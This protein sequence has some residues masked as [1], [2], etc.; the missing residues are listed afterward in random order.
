MKKISY[1]LLIAGV[2]SATP[3][4]ADEAELRARIDKLSAE[5]EALKAEM[6]KLNTKTEAIATQQE[7][8]AQQPSARA[9]GSVVGGAPGVS[10]YIA[11][12][13]GTV[14]Q[15]TVF[16][17]GEIN[18]TR[19]RNDSSQTQADLR[20][21]VIGLGH[22]FSERTRFVSEFEFEHAITS[23]DDSGETEVEQFW[24]DHKLNDY[25]NLKAGLFLIPAGLLNESHEP[26]LYYGVERNFVE[27]AIIPSTWREGGVGLYGSA[28]GGLAWD[29]GVTTGFD[30][31]KW[32]ATSADGRESPLGSIHQELQLAKA[33]DLSVYGA[34]NYRGLPG[35][36]AGASIFTGK[37]GHG[38]ADFLAPNAR[39]TLWDT[40]VRW[41]PGK[42]DL[43]ALYAKGTIS[44]TEELNL[45]FIGQPTPVPKEFFGWYAQAAYKAW[46]S[47]DYALTPFL[48]YERYNTA[49]KYAAVPVDSGI[50]PSQTERV[51]TYGLHFNVTP[52]VVF[53]TDY[54]KF[55]VDSNRDRFDLGLGLLF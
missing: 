7:N 13:A 9:V 54:Q 18:Y 31:S 28:A 29:V 35:F 8:V 32:D 45:S 46:Q 17:Y 3:A 12:P 34:L 40:H 37:V 2:I 33:R 21:A 49:S 39:V 43:A 52:N 36:V 44:D 26:T 38:T 24:V 53:K 55:K 48:R 10:G 42:W 22:R 5:L 20:R 14:G 4:L 15:T 23:A 16:G 6:N 19:P 47:G 27:T 1:A 51:L 11:S 41:T 30:L 50:E 25:A